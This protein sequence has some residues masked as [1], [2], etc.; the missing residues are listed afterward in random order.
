MSDI[1]QLK[2]PRT[3]L[4]NEFKSVIKSNVF[5]WNYYPRTDEQSTPSQL[6]HS[7][8]KRP[9]EIKYPLV[10]CDGVKF[11]YDVLEE[12]L[13]YNN[14]TVQCYYRINLNMVLPQEGNQQTP[15]HVDHE[16]PHNNVL[17]YFTSHQ[18]G[19][20]GQIIVDDEH[21][22]PQEDD[23]IIFNGIPHSLMLPR[24]GERIALVATYI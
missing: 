7:F 14:I 24:D 2:N 19:K 18:E 8:I 12:I 1:I 17:I 16:F 10:L 15:V 21:F 13:N 22:Y 3:E 20:G 9:A 4:Y 5:N 11:V 6:S 23:V